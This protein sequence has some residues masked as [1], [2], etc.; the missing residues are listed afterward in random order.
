M[1][2]CKGVTQMTEVRETVFCLNMKFHNFFSSQEF[3]KCSYSFTS[4]C[5]Q[6]VIIYLIYAYVCVYLEVLYFVSKPKPVS[7]GLS[8]VLVDV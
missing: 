4:T 2:K 8:H 3:I 7:L 1:A 5:F 6:L